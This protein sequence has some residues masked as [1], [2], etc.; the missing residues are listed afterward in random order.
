MKQRFS[1]DL[2]YLS[3]CLALFV[4]IAVILLILVGFTFFFSLKDIEQCYI[5]NEVYYEK[6]GRKA[7]KIEV[8][9]FQLLKYLF[10]EIEVYTKQPMY[11]CQ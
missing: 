5:T 11:L 10:F 7:F 8:E 9:D 6:E 2:N 3:K 1:W 4:G